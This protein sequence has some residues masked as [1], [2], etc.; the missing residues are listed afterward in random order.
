MAPVD[1]ILVEGYKRDAHQKIEVWR[2]E[3]GHDMIQP[4]DTLVRAVAT[5][6]VGLGPLAV[7]ILDLNDT[8]A[9][10]DFILNEVNLRAI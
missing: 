10:A 9:I 8:G 5:D 6:A 7:P 3:T 1:L 2:R 4:H